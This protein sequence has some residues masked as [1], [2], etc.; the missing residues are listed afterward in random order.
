MESVA[1]VISALEKYPITKEELEETRLGRH[2]NNL[3]KKTLNTELSKRAK[4]LLK[5]WRKIA[6]VRQES[7]VAASGVTAEADTD[8]LEAAFP[9]TCFPKSADV[10]NRNFPPIT[11]DL[12]IIQYN[13]RIKEVTAVDS[14]E[15][16]PSP[17]AEPASPGFLL[18]RPVTSS[19]M[20]PQIANHRHLAR[21]NQVP[22]S[23]NSGLL[24]PW[25][26][27]PESWPRV[28]Q[29]PGSL[30]TISPASCST[31]PH[32]L[33]AVASDYSAIHKCPQ[34][35]LPFPVNLMEH[36]EEMQHSSSFQPSTF[37]NENRKLPILPEIGYNQ[38]KDYIGSPVPA[39]CLDTERIPSKKKTKR[40]RKKGRLKDFRVNLDGPQSDKME[41]PGRLKERRITYNPMT[42]Q[43]ILASQKTMVANHDVG[44][45]PV[46]CGQVS[47]LRERNLQIWDS[48]D[49]QDWKE[50]AKKK[51]I[52]KY[53][54]SQCHRLSFPGLEPQE[55]HEHVRD[56]IPEDCCPTSPPSLVLPTEPSTSISGVSREVS[57]E[58]VSR[59][60]TENWRGVNGCY[61]D[62]GNW[63]DWAQCIS[64]DPYRDEGKLNILPYVCLD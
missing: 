7:V 18:Y 33:A 41:R 4:R 55:Y 27:K 47:E 19:K 52:Q 42:G 60:H 30:E 12:S 15:V 36:V 22:A 43:I 58:D 23:P 50:F 49:K 31:P 6:L 16:I 48:M 25:L 28:C 32:S 11:K 51:I 3:R 17:T 44:A 13:T 2:I 62:K 1:E 24:N 34:S 26:G 37:D 21:S 59:L 20:V 63:Y 8:T 9:E 54:S 35:A 53:L 64:L 46:S 14:P 39:G 5:T 40:G 38:P 57:M 56:F 10:D 61:D 29:E 45:L